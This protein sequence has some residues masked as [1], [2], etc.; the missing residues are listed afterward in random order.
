M[1]V[2]GEMASPL[3]LRC[4]SCGYSLHGLPADDHWVRCPE[5]GAIADLATERIDAAKRAER[6]R[7]VD[8]EL[9]A[10]VGSAGLALI[11]LATFRLLAPGGLPAPGAASIRT[12]LLF[13]GAAGVIVA[14][15]VTIVA[16]DHLPRIQRF[17]FALIAMAIVF[18]IPSSL[19]AL[20]LVFL[21]A[22]A[23]HVWALW[24][25]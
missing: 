25:R 14:Y 18:I 3:D 9:P 8:R 1:N 7:R 11:L 10:I 2:T 21:W 12:A 6:R 4:P 22:L 17:A 19:S 15:A 24:R 23:F 16:W 20:A 5:C 13:A